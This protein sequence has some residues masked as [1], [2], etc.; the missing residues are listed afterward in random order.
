MAVSLR[1][2]VGPEIVAFV[3][4]SRESYVADR[5]ESGDDTAVAARAADEQIAAMFPAGEP[6]PGHLL[7]CL[8]EDGQRVGSLWIGPVPGD[9]PGSWW[10][11][12]IT[13]EEAHRRRGLGKAAMLLA[14][15]Q[16]R[17]NGATDL[18]LN[19]F[20][21]NAVARHLYERLGYSTVAIRM[22][23]KL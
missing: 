1:K 18:G 22:N 5:V 10:V 4:A 3:A 12:D 6:G 17:S 16:A 7:Y 19:V 23:K 15:S 9:Q 20:G 11:W 13:I 8:E 2:M 21:G 14:E